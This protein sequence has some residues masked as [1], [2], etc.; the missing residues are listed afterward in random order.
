MPSPRSA[1]PLGHAVCSTRIYLRLRYTARH[2]STTS[3][4]VQAE[5]PPT[6][7]LDPSFTPFLKSVDLSARRR[8]TTRPDIEVTQ[9]VSSS[10]AKE[11]ENV[12]Q[13]RKKGFGLLR[14]M[15]ES[16]DELD[17]VSEER[18]EE[19]RSPAT[20]LGSKRLGIAVLP[21]ELVEGIQGI[22]DG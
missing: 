22:V 18:R 2:A 13:S 20:V 17:T 19:R 8:T 12:A 16:G 6:P 7:E 21:Q 1:R 10:S 3:Q 4:I 9:G 14:D 15:E 5:Q 11:R